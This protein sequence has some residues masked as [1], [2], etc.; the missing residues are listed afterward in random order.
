M[1]GERY[2]RRLLAGLEPRLDPEP[3][4]FVLA[5]E[6]VVPAGMR[7]VATIVEDEGLTL[8]V[9]QQEADRAGPTSR[10]SA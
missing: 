9:T 7:P 1:S 8:V 2:L 5:P 10:R 4:V 3:H 6:G